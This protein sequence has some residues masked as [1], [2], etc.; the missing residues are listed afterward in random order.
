MPGHRRYWRRLGKHRGPDSSVK[1]IFPLLL[2]SILFPGCSGKRPAPADTFREIRSTLLHGDL[3]RARNEADAEYRRFSSHDLEWAWKFRLLEGDALASQG[4]SQ[5]LLSLLNSELPPSLSSGDL[6]ARKHMLQAL[7]YSHLGDIAA[8]DRNLQQAQ[9]ICALSHCES[10]GEVAGIGGAVAVDRNDTGQAESYFR[11]SL[12]IAR[13]QGDKY[14]ELAALL[15]LGVAELGKE[16]FDESIQWS[17]DAQNLAQTIASG[18]DEEKALGNLGYAYYKMG[19][20]DRS[21]TEYTQASQK[22]GELGAF[23]DQVEW[24]NDLGLVYFQTDQLPL[25]ENYYRQSLALAQKSENRGQVI[26]ALTALAYLA[27][28]TNKLDEAKQYGQQ[29][30]QLAH[31]TGDRAGELPPMVVQGKI[32]ARS[33]DTQNAERIFLEASADPKSDASL[34]WEAQN[35]LAKLYEDQHQTDQADKQYRK[36]LATF[37]GARSTLQ[38]EES[39]LPFLSNATHLYDDYLHFL[40][41]HGKTVAALQLADY[42]RAQ[43]LA[44]GLGLLGKNPTSVPAGPDPRQAAAKTGSTILYYWLGA[45]ESYRWTVTPRQITLSQLP[46]ASEINEAVER[47]RKELLG[48]RNVLD[49]QSPAGTQLF[50]LL[51][52]ASQPALTGNSRVVII[53]DGSLSNLNFETLLVPAPNLHYWIEDVTIVN[54]S[55]LRLLAAS[56]TS[57]APRERKLLLIGDPLSPSQEYGELPEAGVEV[58]NIEKHFAP[59]ERQ[60][61]T[62]EKATAP[63]YLASAPQ[64]FDYVHFVAHGTSTRL[65]PLES[66]VILSKSSA[67]EDSFKLYAR[68]I[69]RHP[70]RAQLVTIS[71][72]YGA[73][74]RAYAGEGLVGLSWAF[75]RAGAHNVIGALWEVSDVSTPRLMDQLYSELQKG[76]SPEAAL[77]SAKLSLLHSDGVFRKPFY[78]APFQIYS[79]S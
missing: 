16:R 38:H 64:Q 23:I 69:I 48:P 12:A 3:V 20:F 53:P 71:T 76:R 43:T 66:A 26:S 59:P 72:C 73:G 13:Q 18:L 70:L 75:L 58:I 35:D 52:G 40:V 31:T 5:D 14:L 10:A 33:G 30:F 8:A 22:A 4:L 21:L 45:N 24:L 9:Q 15:N 17:S 51:V 2:L 61:Y 57:A 56:R 63:A 27:V 32:A 74:T 47:Y 68:D 36:A 78:W 60:V 62:R 34:S 50:D 42:G 11:K 39:R 37:E 55:S 46:P 28:Q 6:A 7:A 65:T 54:A 29:A 19:D 25:A 67:E 44:E 79:G 41:H 49:T 77:R 1:W